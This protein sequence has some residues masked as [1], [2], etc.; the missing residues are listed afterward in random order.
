MVGGAVHKYWFDKLIDGI[1]SL[2]CFLKSS[3]SINFWEK[4]DEIYSGCNLSISPDIYQ[5]EMASF[6][7]ETDLYIIIKWLCLSF[8]ISFALKSIL[9]SIKLA[10]PAFFCLAYILFSSLFFS[11]ILL[12]LNYLCLEWVSGQQHVVW[13]CLFM[14]SDKF[15][16]LVGVFKP[17]I[18]HRLSWIDIYSL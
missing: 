14:Q 2:I 8:I 6:F 11:P 4:S 10:V 17:Y 16:N 15:C 5:E 7:C 3:Y 9:S 18:F 13:S 1:K 12:L